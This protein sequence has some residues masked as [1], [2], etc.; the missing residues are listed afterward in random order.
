MTLLF[1]W[2]NLLF[3]RATLLLLFFT[4]ILLFLA[5]TL[6]TIFWSTFVFRHGDAVIESEVA[7]RWGDIVVHKDKVVIR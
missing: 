7:L 5:V 2:K 3:V 4:A 6:L 1:T